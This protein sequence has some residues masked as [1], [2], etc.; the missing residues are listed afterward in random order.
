MMKDLRE[1]V[2]FKHFVIRSLM[3]YYI[4]I[5]SI[6][7]YATVCPV[8]EN[9][10]SMNGSQAPTSSSV[11]VQCILMWDDDITKNRSMYCLHTIQ[12]RLVAGQAG[13]RVLIYI[14]SYCINPHTT[15]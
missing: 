12:G 14:R 1:E 7:H 6:L 11:P 15:Q 4:S 10:Y 2:L 8:N 5:I 9:M 3:D 13:L